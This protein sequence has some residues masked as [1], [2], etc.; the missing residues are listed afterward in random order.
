MSNIDKIVLIGGNNII[1][2]IILYISLN[3][4]TILFYIFI[5]NIIKKREL[6]NNI[7][8]NKTDENNELDNDIKIKIEK[9]L[10][11]ERLKQKISAYIFLILFIIFIIFIIIDI[12]NIINKIFVYKIFGIIILLSM[13]TSIHFYEYFIYSK[14]KNKGDK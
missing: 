14:I 8:Q 13:Y 11:K 7:K 6:R 3:S 2:Y 10:N 5:T 12:Y 1:L 4:F 9:Y